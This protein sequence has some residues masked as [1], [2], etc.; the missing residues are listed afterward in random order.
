MGDAFGQEQVKF[1][2]VPT[3]STSELVARTVSN[4]K[5]QTVAEKSLPAAESALGKVAITSPRPDRKALLSELKDGLRTTLRAEA[6]SLIE[7][8]KGNSD[9]YLIPESEIMLYNDVAK[10]EKGQV[11]VT[12]PVSEELR[13]IAEGY[14]QTQ[15]DRVEVLLS[16]DTRESLTEDHRRLPPGFLD[17]IRSRAPEANGIKR[18]SKVGVFLVPVVISDTKQEAFAFYMIK[19]GESFAKF[20]HPS[21]P[22]NHASTVFL[23]IARNLPKVL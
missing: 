8:L 2:S 7:F 3:T 18:S 20:H 17:R 21:E 12:E 23:G 13:T 4:F 22:V 15:P 6:G 14:T 16:V 19:P 9:Q 11:N 10:N 5:L 1:I